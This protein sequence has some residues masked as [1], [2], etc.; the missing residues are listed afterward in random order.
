[1]SDLAC[2][3]GWWCSL[4]IVLVVAGCGSSDEKGA[5]SFKGRAFK[6]G[7]IA[8][9]VVDDETGQP[10]INA[11]I[12]VSGV[13]TRSRSDGSFEVTAPAGRA[14]VQVKSPGFLDTL[15]DVAVGEAPVKVPYKL[16]KKEAGQMVGRAGGS[17]RFREAFLDVPPGA[18]AD[19]TTMTLTHLS[20]V[21]VAAVAAAPQFV[22]D[23]KIPRR[24]LA[25]VDVETS[26]PPAMPVRVRVPVPIDATMDSVSG[27]MTGADGQWSAPLLPDLVGGGF[28][29]F[30]V[31]GNARFGVAIDAR[32][33]DGRKVAYL[34]AEPGDAPVTTGDVLGGGMEVASVSRAVAVVDPTGSRVEIPPG[35]RVK[36][37]PPAEEEPPP[38]GSSAARA[39]AAPFA[40]EATLMAGR[41]RVVVP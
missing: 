26:A 29:E 6:A 32:K 25:T 19:G 8:G 37:E 13:A 39:G 40:G 41:A 35:S 17:L 12:E 28:A 20:R 27:F 15:R 24:V 14:H 31:S 5:R 38:A 1:M 4:A 10:I 23:N 3:S 21:R 11:E 16:A 9:T 18:V 34:V 30:L 36:L 2:R 33:A 7:T 22:D